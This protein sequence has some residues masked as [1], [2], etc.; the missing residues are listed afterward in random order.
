MEEE[1]HLRVR[2]FVHFFFFFFFFLVFVFVV[3]VG[4]EELNVKKLCVK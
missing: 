2:G 4:G 1:T 3:V